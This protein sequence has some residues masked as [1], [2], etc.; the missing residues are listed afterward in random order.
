[1]FAGGAQDYNV[2][3]DVLRVTG[4]QSDTDFESVELFTMNNETSLVK[5]DG[6]RKIINLSAANGADILKE[7]GVPMSF[8]AYAAEKFGVT[9]LKGMKT[10]ALREAVLATGKTAADFKL[11]RKDYD[12]SHGQFCLAS[13]KITALFASD[14]NYRQTVK[15]TKTGAVTTFRYIKPTGA[16]KSANAQVAQLKA[17]LVAAGIELPVELA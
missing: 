1:V 6:G 5:H 8:K 2:A 4:L 7:N 12:A 14:P 17:L 13:R 10:P 15:P 3:R 9:L 11:A 16:A